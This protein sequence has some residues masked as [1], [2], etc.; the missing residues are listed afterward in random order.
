MKKFFAAFLALAMS[1]VLLAGCSSNGSSSS[2]TSSAPQGP[3]EPTSASTTGGKKFGI[4][5][6][7]QRNQTG[8][9]DVS[10]LLCGTFRSNLRSIG[11][12]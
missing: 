12:E 5:Y 3:S 9:H 4:T 2:T 6:R 8:E 10:Q 1:L 11:F 7:K